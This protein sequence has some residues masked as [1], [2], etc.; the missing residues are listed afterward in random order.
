MTI[1]IS[2]THQRFAVDLNDQTAL[3]YPERFLGPNWKNVLN[4]WIYLDTLS[5]EE[6]RIV[7]GR[8]VSGI[9][10]YPHSTNLW[11]LK[12]LT[13]RAAEAA[14]ATIG[15]YYARVA[16]DFSPT[17]VSAYATLELIGSHNLETF[18]ILPL[19]LNP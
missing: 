6:Q 8:V 5:V 9:E 3:E 17:I 12:C 11:N 14:E 4:F 10:D 15:K 2:K 16:W 13:K 1:K 19:F 18:T 7:E